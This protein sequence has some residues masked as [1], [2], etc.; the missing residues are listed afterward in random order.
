MNKESYDA[1]AADMFSLGA[2]FYSLVTKKE[3]TFYAMIL[4][5]QSNAYHEILS[6]LEKSK[7]ATFLTDLI[8]KLLSL[9]PKKRPK[10]NEVLEYLKNPI[11]VDLNRIGF[12]FVDEHLNLYDKSQDGLSMIFERKDKED[13]PIAFSINDRL[14]TYPIYKDHFFVYDYQDKITK[15]VI[16]FIGSYFNVRSIAFYSSDVIVL[17]SFYFGKPSTYSLNLTSGIKSQLRNHIGSITCYDAHDSEMVSYSKDDH[18]IRKIKG[19]KMES[20]KMKIEIKD[21]CYLIKF[22]N[23]RIVICTQEH[24]LIV[25]DDQKIRPKKLMGNQDTVLIILIHENLIITASKDKRILIFD[26][27]KCLKKLEGHEDQIT[28]LMVHERILLSSSLDKTVR[29]WDIDTGRCLTIFK[30]N[31]KIQTIFSN[32]KK[33]IQDTKSIKEEVKTEHPDC[34][35][36]L[37][38]GHCSKWILCCT[39]GNF[40]NLKFCIK[41][42]IKIEELPKEN[43]CI[44]SGF[45]I[46]YK[47]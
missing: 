47:L 32:S 20:D 4:T 46:K 1:F 8:L 44:D 2:L 39:H 18:T 43:F 35:G 29:F 28:S 45:F 30:N 12:H 6:D 15:P 27:T 9:D 17:A 11:F 36:L 26:E 38:C 14:L 37:K 31:H 40:K 13:P 21:Q 3:K 25:I 23:Q 41:N 34:L 16:I 19:Q 22:F 5:D 33:S 24:S 42:N 7:N 10:I